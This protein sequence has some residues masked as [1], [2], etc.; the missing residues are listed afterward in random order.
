MKYFLITGLLLISLNSYSQEY[1]RAVGL[2]GG[3]TSGITYKQFLDDETAVEGILS[4]KRGGIQITVLHQIHEPALFEFSDNLYFV[5]GYGGHFGYSFSKKFNFFFNKYYYEE[6]TFYP[7]IGM[8]AFLGLE[9]QI[10]DFPFVVSFDYK[11]FFEFSIP[12]F[13]KINLGDFAFSFKYTF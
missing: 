1:Y 7:I 4:F 5:Y 6:D 2:R 11:P 13:F 3:L 9:Y 8:D 12:R 10:R